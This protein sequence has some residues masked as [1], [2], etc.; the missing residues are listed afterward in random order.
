MR[1]CSGCKKRSSSM[2]VHSEPENLL[3]LYQ[4]PGGRHR[5]P[6]L[7]PDGMSYFDCKQGTP[8]YGAVAAAYGITPFKRGHRENRF[9]SH[10]YCSRIPPGPVTPKVFFPTTSPPL[11]ATRASCA[12]RFAPLR[13]GPGPPIPYF[14]S[15]VG[16]RSVLSIFHYW[17]VS[18]RRP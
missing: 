18:E 8:A 11:V 4:V 6:Q 12:P 5:R 3:R 7:P 15:V 9:A 16:V 2:S 14:I 13:N 10:K 17:R 1:H